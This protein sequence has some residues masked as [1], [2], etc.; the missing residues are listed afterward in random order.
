MSLKMLNLMAAAGAFAATATGPFA[1]AEKLKKAAGDK[2]I[3]VRLS[4]APHN[5]ALDQIAAR[6]WAALGERSLGLDPDG[7]WLAR[8]PACGE[9]RRD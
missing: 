4:G 7:N 1:E 2:A 6:M 3:L 9:A 5:I 8:A